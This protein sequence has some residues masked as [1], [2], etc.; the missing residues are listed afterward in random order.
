MRKKIK[1]IINDLNNNKFQY[2]GIDIDS[3]EILFRRS[4]EESNKVIIEFIGAIHGLMY[5]KKNSEYPGDVYIE[6][7]F[8]KECLQ[9]RKYD[10]KFVGKNCEEYNK[11]LS[12]CKLWLIEQKSGLNIELIKKEEIKDVS[13]E[14]LNRKTWFNKD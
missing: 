3:N 9:K 8:I 11:F 6:N 7:I 5:I 1:I 10:Y 12:R 13:D 4:F 2:Q 14:F